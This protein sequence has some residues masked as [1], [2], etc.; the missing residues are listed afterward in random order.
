[1]PRKKRPSRWWWVGALQNERWTS[2][3]NSPIF[4]SEEEAW[5]WAKAAQSNGD[6]AVAPGI[7]LVPRE[8]DIAEVVR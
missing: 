7:E 8:I 4:P 3:D 2:L 1:M 5:E 6:Q